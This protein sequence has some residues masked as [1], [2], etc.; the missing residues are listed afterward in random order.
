MRE[1]VRRSPRGALARSACARRASL[2]TS[3]LTYTFMKSHLLYAIS[4]R[5]PPSPTAWREIESIQK[6]LNGGLTWAHDRLT[7]AREGS[8]ARTSFTFP[9]IQIMPSARVPLAPNFRERLEEAQP[10]IPDAWASGS[11][12]VRDNL[13]NA[14]LVVAF[15]RVVSSRHPEL[16]FELRDDGGFVLPG[17]AWIKGGK[18]ELQR[19]WLNRNRERALESSGDV[20]A[21]VPFLWAEREA[22]EGRF[23]VDQAASEYAE[24]PE[25]RELNMDWNELAS[26]GLE[27]I[28]A[29]IVG[30]LAGAAL[31]PTAA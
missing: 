24:V 23:F 20:E 9:L 31:A 15:L 22:L 19:E 10:R 7:L 17:A 12:R 26:V 6:E 14:H 21:A 18:M 29:R 1:V 3:S 27:D 13:W 2:L 28:A 16:L 8:A 30:R 11:T 4:K 25:I 5:T